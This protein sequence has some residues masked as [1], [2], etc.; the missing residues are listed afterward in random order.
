MTCGHTRKLYIQSNILA[1]YRVLPPYPREGK[2]RP[3]HNRITYINDIST[4]ENVIKHITKCA[5]GKST[6]VILDSD[7]SRDHVLSELEKYSGFVTKGNYLIVED[8][9]I[10][11]L[12]PDGTMLEGPYATVKDFIK[13]HSEYCR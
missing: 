2:K 10:N 9:N 4:S 3:Q 11:P 7:H 6:M 5:E 8:T 12:M 1:K 13:V